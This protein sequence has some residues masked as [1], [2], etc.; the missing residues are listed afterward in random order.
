MIN[1][2]SCHMNVTKRGKTFQVVHA[3]YHPESEKEWLFVSGNYASTGVQ[4]PQGYSSFARILHTGLSERDLTIR[5][6]ST[7]EWAVC[8]QCEQ[9]IR[10]LHGF[11]GT[12]FF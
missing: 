3:I 9:Q 7:H 11:G 8:R 6:G 5:L 2:H 1:L 10:E 12:T 4:G